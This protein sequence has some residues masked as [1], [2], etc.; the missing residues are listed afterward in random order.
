M[1]SDGRALAERRRRWRWRRRRRR[2][3]R[4][5]SKRRAGRA[6]WRKL[7]EAARTPPPPFFLGCRRGS[8]NPCPLS[9]GARPGFRDLRWAL[10]RMMGCVRA[11]SGRQRRGASG[12]VTYSERARHWGA[13]CEMQGRCASLRSHLGKGKGHRGVA[14]GPSV[15][16]GHH[17]DPAG[18]ARRLHW[19]HV[20]EVFW[21]LW[22]CPPSSWGPL[23][24]FHPAKHSGVTVC[25]QRVCTL[26]NRASSMP[27]KL[28]PL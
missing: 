9:A 26:L 22:H 13:G 10:C 5:R 17:A 12:W 18:W 24:H 19:V 1:R 25:A 16:A 11:L 6:T 21:V 15:R 8:G 14:S 4:W 3:R 23:A 2:R 7:C 28:Y 27:E 20:G